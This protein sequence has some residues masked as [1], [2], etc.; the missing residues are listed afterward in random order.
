M[1][2]R[3]CAMLLAAGL[4]LLGTECPSSLPDPEPNGNDSN[5]NSS[6]NSNSSG[7]GPFLLTIK[8]NGPVNGEFARIYGVV[9]DGPQDHAS[10]ANRSP[11]ADFNVTLTSSNGTGQIVET[12]T[13]DKGTK[14]ALVAVE[15]DGGVTSTPPPD[16]I[17]TVPMQFDGWTGNTTG[18]ATGTG[19]SNPAAIYIEM[20]KDKTIE[21]NF[22]A[23]TPIFV[24]VDSDPQVADCNVVIHVDVD[25]FIIPPDPVQDGTG[26]A[27]KHSATGTVFLWGSYRDGAVMM[28]ELHD[29][30]DNASHACDQG[31]VNPCF[32]FVEWTGDCEGSGKTCILTYGS[33][34]QATVVLEAQ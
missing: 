7:D 29:A 2:I 25:R 9:N 13:Y 26:V 1:K 18:L 3:H 28:L 10:L 6:D 32:V 19:G 31:S 20:D 8:I 34:T 5:S 21:A 22:S 12:F 27:V 14:I 23:M 11:Q 4:F 24:R 16:N 17:D 30:L 15:G 33:A